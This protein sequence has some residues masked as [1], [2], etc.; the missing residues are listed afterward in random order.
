M[1]TAMLERKRYIFS[2]DI[3]SFD[4]KLNNDYD[5]KPKSGLKLFRGKT[6]IFNEEGSDKFFYKQQSAPVVKYEGSNITIDVPEK[7]ELELQHIKSKWCKMQYKV[8]LNGNSIAS[9]LFSSSFFPYTERY[10]LMNCDIDFEDSDLLLFSFF[11][12]IA[13]ETVCTF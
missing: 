4:C 6:E 3:I 2:T 7:G 10:Q 1:Y 5:L 12:W 8:K 9:L 11:S 13:H